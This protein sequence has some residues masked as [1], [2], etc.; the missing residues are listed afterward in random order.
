MME[1]FFNTAGPNI[2][3]DHY[4][5]PSLERVDWEEIQRLIAQKR[6]FLLHAPRQTGKTSVLLEMMEALNA[7]GRYH[8]LYVNIEAAQTVRNDA[9]KGMRIVCEAIAASARVYKVEPGLRSRCLG[10]AVGRPTSRGA[11]PIFGSMGGAEREA[12]RAFSGRGGRT[13]RRYP[14]LATAPDPRRLRATSAGV[15]TKPRAL[16]PAGHSGLSHP[17]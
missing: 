14:D 9:D 1:R 6:Y 8:A 2:P 11:D 13:R 16:W 15:S 7:Q 4:H 10:F 12:D 5:I 3:E 17:P